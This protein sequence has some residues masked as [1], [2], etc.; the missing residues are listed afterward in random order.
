MPTDHCC[1]HISHCFS[2]FGVATGTLCPRRYLDGWHYCT[3]NIWF[4]KSADDYP[5]PFNKS[6]HL[7][8]G[9]KLGG[10]GPGGSPHEGVDLSA[11][12]QEMLVDY[13]RI[14]QVRSHRAGRDGRDVN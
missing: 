13:V 4:S 1:H 3:K 5:A 2:I 8:M 9:V 14:T 10:G 12:P 11:L 7:E 6:F